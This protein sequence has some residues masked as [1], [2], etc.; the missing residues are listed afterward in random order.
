MTEKLER[1]GAVRTDHISPLQVKDLQSGEIYEARMV[2]YSEGGI[3]FGSD[4]VFENRAKIYICVQRS[5]YSFSSGVLEYYSGEI[6]WRKK[7]KR[8]LFKYEY[9]I[10]L[11]SDSNQQNLDAKPAKKAKES[12]KHPRKPFVRTIRFGIHEGL[13]EGTTKNIS[14]S[15]VFIATE[16]KF[17]VGQLVKLK[18]PVNKG[19]TKDIIGQIVWVNHEGFGLKF[20]AV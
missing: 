3:C 1:R 20:K 7:S 17:E 9:G 5:P 15:G 6:R 13:Y 12:R 19:K 4:G 11:V 14:K 18:L 16:E 10:Q 2:N 8:S